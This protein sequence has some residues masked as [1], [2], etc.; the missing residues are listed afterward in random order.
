MNEAEIWSL[1]GG[2][3]PQSKQIRMS[4]DMSHTPGSLWL[5]TKCQKHNVQTAIQWREPRNTVEFPLCGRV[6]S[7]FFE[8]HFRG[9]DAAVFGCKK[10]IQYQMSKQVTSTSINWKQLSNA[11]PKSPQWNLHPRYRIHL[12]KS[13]CEKKSNTENRL[14]S[15]GTRF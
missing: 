13:K 8:P 7:Q 6:S 4:P 12:G 3:R 1:L 5:K 15:L 14:Y 9:R 2:Q 11:T 10:S